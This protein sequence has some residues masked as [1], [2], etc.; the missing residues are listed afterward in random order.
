MKS[1]M[2]R[3]VFFDLETGGLDPRRHPII[4]IGA[5]AVDADLVAIESFEIKVQF[6]RKK[7]NRDS[8]RK[9]HYQPGVW[10]REAATTQVR[11]PDV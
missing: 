5:V 3:I 7:A 2:P 1:R 10:A 6:S 4:Q 8:L 11:M 9:N